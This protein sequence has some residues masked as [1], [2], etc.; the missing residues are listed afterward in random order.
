MILM[1][2]PSQLYKFIG[3]RTFSTN[4]GLFAGPAMEITPVYPI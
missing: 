4:E 1:F 2:G 3:S